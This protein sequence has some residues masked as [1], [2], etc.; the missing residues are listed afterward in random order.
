MPTR[1]GDD[2]GAF[3]EADGTGGGYSENF[4]NVE[5]AGAALSVA[6]DVGLGMMLAVAGGAFQRIRWHGGAGG[7]KGA[8][9]AWG[10][11]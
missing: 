1:Q 3:L 4:A 11:R 8:G 6:E 10:G 5:V 7:G 2:L 9:K